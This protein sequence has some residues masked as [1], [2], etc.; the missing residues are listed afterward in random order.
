MKLLERYVLREHLLPFLLGF[1]VVTLAIILDFLFDYL[2]LIVGKG[3]PPLIV[4]KLFLLALGWITVLSFPCGVLV[5]CLMTFG[6]MSQ[7]NEIVALRAS[8]V[9]LG[10]VLA[11]VLGAATVLAIGLSLFNNFVLP[12]TNHAFASLSLAIHR[13]AP[14]AVIRPGVFIDDF[15]DKSL[16]VGTVD[17]RSGRLENIT[18]YDFSQ[19][20]IPVTILARDGR[21]HY[22][23]D[24]TVLR[25]DLENGEIH[26]VPPAAQGHKYRRLKF[27]RHTILLRNAG[28]AL[29]IPQRESRS[30]REMN[31]AALTREI[32]R[33]SDSRRERE[34]RLAAELDSLGFR[35][36]K[37]FS[38][39]AVDAGLYPG[40]PPA[41]PRGGLPVPGAGGSAPS[42]LV[43]MPAPDRDRLLTLHNDLLILRKKISSYT[44]EV[45]KKFSIP[46]ACI[47][48]VLLGAPIGM[49][50]RRGGLATSAISIAFIILYY[51]FLIGGE[52]LADRTVLPPAL[53]MWAPNVV[54]GAPGLWLTWRALRG[55]DERR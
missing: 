20:D 28:A 13:K 29:E 53:A 6:R 17:D 2:D 10:R 36:W 16:L 44:V 25:L 48:F 49:R 30:E 5:A 52:Q 19:G 51:M 54:L 11:P 15:P 3:I 7:D 50:T 22:S 9:N 32:D 4:A 21:L 46:A 33:L 41:P 45:H 55:A 23:E 27:D 35:D 24:G 1:G 47:V 8:G 37:E 14:T 38:S 31:I 26:E 12:E 34:A 18:I 40:V 43:E 39:R 42:P